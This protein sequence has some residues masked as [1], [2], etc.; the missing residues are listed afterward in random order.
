MAASSRSPR[1]WLALCGLVAGAAVTLTGIMLTTSGGGGTRRPTTSPS[2]SR[3]AV[4]ARILSPAG[5]DQ[6][7]VAYSDQSTCADLSG[8]DGASAVRL[9]RTQ[10]AWFFSDS[11]LGPAGPR[12]GFSRLSGFVHNLVVVQTMSGQRSRFVTIT[13]GHACA[14][15][16]GPGRALSVVSPGNAGGTPGQRYWDGDGIRAG[17]SI[18]RF[19][20]RYLP[21]RVPYVP[22]AT[23]M[24]SFPIDQLRREGRGSGYGEVIRPAITPVPSVSLPGNPPIVWGTSVLRDKRYAY[25]Y[26]W[27]AAHAQSVARSAYLARVAVARIT[28][29]AAWRYYAGGG[30]W[31]ANQ[32]GAR[33]VTDGGRLNLDAGFSVLRISGRYWLIEQGGGFGSPDIAAYPAMEPFGPFGTLAPLWLYHARGIGLSAADNYQ[34]MYSV[35]A[36]PALSSRSR[37]VISY[38]VNSLAVDAGCVSI[39]MVT[40]AII[41]PRFVAVPRSV[42]AAAARGRY[43]HVRAVAGPVRYPAIVASQ[44]GRWYDAWAYRH[45]CPPVPAVRFV[46]VR[47]TGTAVRVRWPSVGIDVRYRVELTATG[48]TADLRRVVLATTVT[49]RHLTPGRTYVVRVIPENRDRRA[50]PGA[51]AMFTG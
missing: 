18:V 29:V 51:S 31:S 41:Q 5:L 45:G 6:Q 44:P 4:N 33:P 25:I 49:F 50:G 9:S 30:R 37:L 3:V 19:Y 34:I 39:A 14:R 48:P 23:V 26:G 21:G 43:E 27:Q 15:P 12:I 38:S 24:A 32:A 20:T 16:H 8:G 28:D 35:Q 10:I 22:V 1:I 11:F 17:S 13:G 40:N 42:F 7:W 46:S 47:R 36:E 2:S